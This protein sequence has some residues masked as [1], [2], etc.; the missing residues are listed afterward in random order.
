MAKP[1]ELTFKVVELVG[2]VKENKNSNW[3]K[4]IAR[5]SY[6]DGPPNIDIR[7]I[8]FKEDGE[9]FLGKGISLTN[10]ECDTAVDILLERGYGSLDQLEYCLNKRKEMFGG[11]FFSEE[12]IEKDRMLRLKLGE[13][14]G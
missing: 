12:E 3:C 14:N 7:N 6:N 1:K 8:Q 11:D 13:K 10:E 5:I 2:P 4:Y 9:Y